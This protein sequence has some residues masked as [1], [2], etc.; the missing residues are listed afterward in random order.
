MIYAQIVLRLEKL[1][2]L[3]TAAIHNDDEN[4]I[5]QAVYE[6]NRK[7]SFQIT[8]GAFAIN[9]KLACNLFFL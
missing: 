5:M 3:A 7:F 2:F 8:I 6:G 4:G 1:I 9:C